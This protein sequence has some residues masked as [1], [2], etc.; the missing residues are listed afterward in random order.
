M[1]ISEIRAALATQGIRLTRALGQNFLH[2]THQLDRIVATA[3]LSPGDK[4]L[5]IGPG[6]G[7]LT[8]RLVCAVPEGRVLAV[9]V[10]RRLATLLQGRVDGQGRLE[11]CVADALRWLREEPRD[12]SGW[13]LVSNLPFSVASPILVELAQSVGPPDR[14][15][16]TLQQEVVERVVAKPDSRDYGVLSLLIQ[17]RYEPKGWF[18]ISHACFWPEPD[19]DSGCVRLDRRGDPL[20][21][22]AR[23][24]QAFERLVRRAFSQRRKMIPKLLRQDWPADRLER[25]MTRADVDV[26]A[27]A[28]HVS[29]D[30][31][32]LMARD[33]AAESE[34]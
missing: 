9:E 31:Y 21:Q 32:V 19:V 26:K 6:L 18:K 27:R 5:E 13:K 15:V 29:L 2:D 1:K 14:M 22:E 8:E 7:P 10:E 11:V 12:W 33:L 17:L 34:G 16:A 24:V 30:Q 23:Q 25:A 3:A 20:L 28:E 4:V